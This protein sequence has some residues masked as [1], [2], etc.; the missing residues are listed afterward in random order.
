MA[1]PGGKDP[2]VDKYIFP[3]GY[4]PS[5]SETLSVVERMGLWVTDIEILRL[6]Y[7]ETL[8]HWY[9]RFQSRREKA[10]ELFD[11]RFCRM[12]EYYLAACEMMFRNGNLMVFQ[13]QLAH[14]RDAVPLTREYLYDTRRSGAAIDAGAPLRLGS[15]C[16]CSEGRGFQTASV[17]ERVLR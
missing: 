8:A 17:P 11:E 12:W 4:I 15:G 5:L 16:R 2:W 14:K 9:E 6:H 3:G 10:L 13:L 1:P 7:A